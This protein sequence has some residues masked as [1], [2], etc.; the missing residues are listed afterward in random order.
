MTRVLIKQ[1][2]LSGL[3]L[4]A[5][6]WPDIAL[7]LSL[8]AQ[9]ETITLNEALKAYPQTFYFDKTG[10]PQG[11]V[12]LIHTP[13]SRHR[14]LANIGYNLSSHGWSTL[15][16]ELGVT[17]E[18]LK[19]SPDFDT[20]AHFRN[21]I[22]AAIS[23]MQEEKGQYN[24]VIISLN[25]SWPVLQGLIDTQ[26]WNPDL[27]QGYI[28]LDVNSELSIK[29]LPKD[30]PILDIAL[31]ETASAAREIRLMQAHRYRLDKFESLSMLQPARP[32]FLRDDRLSRRL[33]GWLQTNVRGMELDRKHLLPVTP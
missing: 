7:S 17:P 11:G 18:T 20:Q 28:L 14:D 25:E 8:E 9:R 24:L 16:L 6:P 1:F 32:E 13:G 27:L 21:Q 22:L 23:Y 12:I 15:N 4:L 29:D 19:N 10:N 30:K 3:L 31:G 5:L 2:V 33:R 26:D